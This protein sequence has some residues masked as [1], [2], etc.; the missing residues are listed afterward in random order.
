MQHHD[1][2][3]RADVQR[4]GGTIESD[5]GRYLFAF[6]EQV[7][8]FGLRDLVDKASGF[9][10]IEEIGLVGC[11]GALVY[12]VQVGIQRGDS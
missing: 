12:Q 11:H 7:E 4:R 5:I 6:R 10:N 8:R 1:R 2:Q 9:E 3:E